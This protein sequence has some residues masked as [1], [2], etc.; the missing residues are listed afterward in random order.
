MNLRSALILALSCCLNCEA[1]AASPV[2]CQTTVES[3]RNLA[4]AFYTKAL[5]DKQPLAAFEQYAS[6]D[7][8][9]H[10]PDVPNGERSAVAKF[11]EGMIKALPEAK[12]EIVRTVAEKDFVVLHAKFT[13]TPGA[14][15]YAIAD[16]FRIKNCSVV[17][18][19]DVV[20][21]PRD[22]TPN[23]ISQF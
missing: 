14:P 6:V 12:W 19:W 11:L 21:P 23:Q 1:Q 8:V 5:I 2:G 4:I 22:G 3:S 7:F 20:E 18:H 16:F 9:E 15:P 10:K 13:P 17:E